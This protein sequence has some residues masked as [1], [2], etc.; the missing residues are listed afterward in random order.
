MDDTTLQYAIQQMSEFYKDEDYLMGLQY[1]R[2]DIT[3]MVEN[4]ATGTDDERAFVIELINL[5][6]Q[7]DWDDCFKL[8]DTMPERFDYI[9]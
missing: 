2:E 1:I 5:C 4:N 9:K 7:E 3:D 8:M 6:D